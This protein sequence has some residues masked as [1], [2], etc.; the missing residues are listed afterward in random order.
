VFQTRV[1]ESSTDPSRGATICSIPGVD[2]FDQK[3]TITLLTSDEPDSTIPKRHDTSDRVEAH[4][5]ALD[6][7]AR[8]QPLGSE[9]GLA[10]MNLIGTCA[11]K[12]HDRIK[13]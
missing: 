5:N 3:G 2:G 13:E 9:A 11:T 4:G 8:E 6:A 1:I 12:S 7:A 10:V